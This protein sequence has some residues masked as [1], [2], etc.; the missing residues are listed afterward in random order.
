MLNCNEGYFNRKDGKKNF[1][2]EIIILYE[3]L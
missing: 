2:E 1:Y 3:R